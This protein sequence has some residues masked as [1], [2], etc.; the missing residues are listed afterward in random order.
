MPCSIPP[1]WKRPQSPIESRKG[2]SRN[3]KIKFEEKGKEVNMCQAIMEMREEERM[4][5]REEIAKHMLK[6]EKYTIEEIASCSNL[7]IERVV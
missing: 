3:S 4:L 2:T 5:E 7:S 1:G 6:L